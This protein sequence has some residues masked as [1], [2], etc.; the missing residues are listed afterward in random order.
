MKT[1]VVNSWQKLL[2]ILLL[3]LH[4]GG[5]DFY[6]PVT[7]KTNNPTK[8][9]FKRNFN[10]I[11][12]NKRY[13]FWTTIT[14]K[15]PTFSFFYQDK[16]EENY[17]NFYKN[18]NIRYYDEL[19]NFYKSGSSV[20]NDFFNEYDHKKILSYFKKKI[21]IQF[22]ANSNKAGWVSNSDELNTIIHDKVSYLEKIIFNKKIKKQKYRL[23]SWKKESN[24]LSYSKDSVLFHQDRFIP[25]IKLIYFPSEVIIDPYEYCI[26]S[27]I[28]NYQFFKN[29]LLTMKGV[30]EVN[31]NYDFNNYEIKKFY[32]KANSL[33]LTATHGLHRRSQTKEN[34]SGIRDFITISYYNHFTRYDLLS[35]YFKSFF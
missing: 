3:P 6:P 10:F 23:S 31:N 7:H 11:S 35:N 9:F 29:S 5:T 30:N 19:L 32:V 25:S 4:F 34:I 16:P 24:S 12:D 8:L 26:G 18:Q 27:H 17:K 2:R 1:F 14:K 15:H 13:K 28:I 21:H 33:L 20:I 22:T